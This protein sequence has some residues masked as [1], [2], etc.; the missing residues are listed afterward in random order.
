MFEDRVEQ[1]SALTRRRLLQSGGAALAVAVI[2]MHSWVPALAASGSSNAPAYLRRSSY[3]PL[4]GQ[5]FT[6]ISGDQSQALKLVSISDVERAGLAG[7]DDAF[8]L[9]LSGALGQTI[10]QAV[11]TFKHPTLGSFDVFVTPVDLPQ[12]SQSYAVVVDRSVAI[13]AGEAPTPASPIVSGA[14]ASDSSPAGAN[15]SSSTGKATATR[16]PG[17]TAHESVFGEVRAH[18]ARRGVAVEVSFATSAHVEQ[19]HAWLLRDD[20]PLGFA[21]HRVKGNRADLLLHGAHRLAAGRYDV[22]LID[23]DGDDAKHGTSR[24]FELR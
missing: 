22:K 11:H 5:S 9:E 14:T 6:A 17:P 24:A 10:E 18:R 1:A 3:I 13:A 12:S 7:A 2:D 23:T 8:V 20:R 21:T 19:V 4:A 16:R 15:R